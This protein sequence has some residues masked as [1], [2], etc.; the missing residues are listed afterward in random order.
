MILSS[1]GVRCTIIPCCCLVRDM[2]LSSHNS[3]G[4]A[5]L[6]HFGVI[7]WHSGVSCTTAQRPQRWLFVQICVGWKPQQHWHCSNGRSRVKGIANPLSLKSL[8][9]RFD[10]FWRKCT[11]QLVEYCPNFVGDG[12]TRIGFASQTDWHSVKTISLVAVMLHYQVR[13]Q[14]DTCDTS[15]DIHSDAASMTTLSCWKYGLLFRIVSLRA[16]D[17]RSN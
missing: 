14:S 8:N 6:E 9:L 4:P 16:S 1:A 12:R 13:I 2:Q 10:G 7:T 11:S 3:C 5:Q 15:T 17:A